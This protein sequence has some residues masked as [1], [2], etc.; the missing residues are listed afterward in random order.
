MALRLH[1]LH[2]RVANL[3]VFM[4]YFEENRKIKQRCIVHDV[5]IGNKI[6]KIC[7]LYFI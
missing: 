5:Y 3:K 2:N 7:E 6:K 1:F 4:P